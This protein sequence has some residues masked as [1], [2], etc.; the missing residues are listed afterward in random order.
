MRAVIVDDEQISIDAVKSSLEKYCPTV[1]IVGIATSVS[2]AI[3][4]I[5]SCNP[6]LLL[7]DIEIDEGTSFDILEE[8]GIKN[9]HIIFITAFNNFAIKAFKFSATDYLLKPFDPLDLVAAIN[10]VSKQNK[11]LEQKE[12][13][14]TIRYNLHNTNKKLALP[15]KDG[16]QMV[17]VSEILYCKSDNS[18]TTIYLQN[19][20]KVV[21]SK[22][23]KEYEELLTDYNFLRVHQTYLTNLNYVHKFSN[24]DGGI[25]ILSNQTKIPVAR[26]RKDKV[27]EGLSKL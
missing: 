2:T 13:L 23:I 4:T 24:E 10:K 20:N 12:K 6:D 18:Y 26:R 21:V 27:L 1:E 25:L 11:D 7:L 9:L 14:D 16:L 22:S 8:I 3:E 17:L 15:S 5:K 19:E